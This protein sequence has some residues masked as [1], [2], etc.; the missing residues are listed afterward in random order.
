M[1]RLLIVACVAVELLL[2][3]TL[4]EAE[5][6]TLPVSQADNCAVFTAFLPLVIRTPASAPISLH[7]GSTLDAPVVYTIRGAYVWVGPG[8]TNP[9]VYTVDDYHVT[10]TAS[11]EM[12]YTFSGNHIYR[13]SHTAAEF[14]IYTIVEHQVYDG[15]NAK[16]HPLLS[17]VGNQVRWEAGPTR[18]I[19][20][21]ASV[22]VEG[23]PRLEFLLPILLLE[24]F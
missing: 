13:G 9:P 22:P 4:C 18:Q 8:A 12:L 16:G 1:K 2:G 6:A 14:A 24:R 19:M 17:Y 21:T 15:G 11:N 10:R 7:A 23:N 5:P 20:V 3:A